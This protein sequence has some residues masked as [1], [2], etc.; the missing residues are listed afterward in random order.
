M[1]MPAISDATAGE[2]LAALPTVEDVRG[3]EAVMAQFPQTEVPVEHLVHGLMY[4]RTALIPAGQALVGAL[5]NAD[6]ICVVCGDITVTTDTGVRRITGYE[7]LPAMAGRKRV[8]FTHSDT[9][10]TVVF[11]TD[12]KDVEAIENSITSEPEQMLSRRLAIATETRDAIEQK[13]Q[14]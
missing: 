4:A 7:V 12:L 5:T 14:P 6:N 8:G 3:L 11:Q 13:E 10:W 2:V 1:T 9:W